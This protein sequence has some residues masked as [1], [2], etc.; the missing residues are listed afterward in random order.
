MSLL[1]GLLDGF[2]SLVVLGLVGRAVV[3]L[4]RNPDVDHDELVPAWERRLTTALGIPVTLVALSTIA[5]G[6]LAIQYQSVPFLLAGIT[7]LVYP[8]FSPSVV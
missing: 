7:L 5:G 2:F 6:P 8:D 4:R 3:L 1:T